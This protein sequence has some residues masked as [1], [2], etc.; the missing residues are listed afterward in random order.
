M[1]LCRAKALAL[2]T[3]NWQ[4]TKRRGEP[5]S[6][7][8]SSAPNYPEEQLSIHLHKPTSMPAEIAE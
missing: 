6:M 4:I 2:E 3:D 5:L 7:V 1:H 8:S